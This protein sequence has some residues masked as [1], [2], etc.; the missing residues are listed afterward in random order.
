LQK[1]GYFWV[2]RVEENIVL[3][4]RNRG[5]Y[6]KRVSEDSVVSILETTAADGKA[7][8]T[9]FHNV[10]GSVPLP[11]MSDEGTQG[12]DGSHTDIGLR[13]YRLLAEGRYHPFGAPDTDPWIGAA[14]GVSALRDFADVYGPNGVHVA[15]HSVMQVAPSSE[16]GVGVDFVVASFL[17]LSLALRASV[18]AYGHSKE[19]LVAEQDRAVH[20]VGTLTAV[21]LGF[22]GVFLASP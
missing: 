16:L 21:N 18:A 13:P 2:A 17:S 19:I 12:S 1:L 15:D 20:D 4:W 6:E 8:S 7:Y 22:E 11:P 5:R 10:V 3:D 14:F 9:R